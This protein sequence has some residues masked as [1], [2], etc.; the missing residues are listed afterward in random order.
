MVSAP[1]LQRRP[2]PARR[3]RLFLGVSILLGGFFLPPLFGS[4]GDDPFRDPLQVDRKVD[5][6]GRGQESIPPA[7]A[8]REEVRFVE[9]WRFPLG[10]PL[11]GPLLPLDPLVVASVESGGVNALS[12]SEGR[13]LWKVDLGKPLRGGPVAFG[14]RVVQA[15]TSGEIVAL[16][17]VSGEP[18]WRRDLGREI[19]HGPTATRESLL[20]PLAAAA[21]VSLGED[22]KERWRVNL[23]SAPSSPIAAC[24]GFVVVGTEAGTVE[25]YDR[26]TGRQLWIV[27]GSSPVRSQPL[28]RR[29]LI[30]FGTADY[31]FNALRYSGRRK[32]SY[33]VGGDVTAAPLLLGNRIY[34]FSFDNYVYA[35][36][37]RTGS[38]VLKVRL[39]HRLSND[40][41]PVSGRLYLSPFTSARLLALGLPDLALAGEYKLD[42]EGD[43]FTT[44]PVR[45]GGR[46]LIGYGRYEGRILALREEAAPPPTPGS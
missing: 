35:L 25:A 34:F 27:Q 15:T 7:A 22:G 44:P 2:A 10:A 12:V 17:A 11:S 39:S 40:A 38:L 30:Y 36:N 8:A 29:G 13:P 26:E 46:I 21:V 4:T 3:T 42:L 31:R 32:W 41:L 37:A 33:K 9:A 45:A 43:W 24:R 20:V 16:D 6:H 19:A 14:G 18:R 28:C 1:D 5:S 23:R